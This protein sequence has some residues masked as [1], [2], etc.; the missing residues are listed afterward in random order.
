MTEYERGKVTVT[1]TIFF[2]MLGN[3][4]FAV[5]FA[6]VRGLMCIFLLDN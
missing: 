4:R 6:D 1:A 2:I 3:K 5:I